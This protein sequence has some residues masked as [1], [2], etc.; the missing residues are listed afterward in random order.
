MPRNNR[1][2]QHLRVPVTADE[3]EHIQRN[4][5][6]CGLAVAAYLR[7]LGLGYEP[8]PVVD[9]ERADDLARAMG[10]LGRLGGLLKLW[11]T[12]DQKLRAYP[13]HQVRHMIPAAL[14]RIL[15]SQG[16]LLKVI[17]RLRLPPERAER[18]GLE[19]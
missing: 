9:A 2:R 16:E 17:Q 15:E 8:R 1:R 4:A 10:D 5:T 11:L 3:A 19:G 14:K 6:A 7:E 12:D 18:Q 13:A